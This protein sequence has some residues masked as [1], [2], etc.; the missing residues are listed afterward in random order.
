VGGIGEPA[1]CSQRQV[2]VVFIES[3]PAAATAFVLFPIF[4]VA[5][6]LIRE[7][8]G[9]QEKLSLG[10]AITGAPSQIGVLCCWRNI[11]LSTDG[12]YR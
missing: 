10:K 11:D 5:F 2:K 4:V 1:V 6:F 8:L 12:G 3:E 7:K 9:V